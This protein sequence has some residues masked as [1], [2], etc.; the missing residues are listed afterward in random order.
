MKKEYEEDLLRQIRALE[1]ERDKYKYDHLTNLMGRIDFEEQFKKFHKDFLESK[2]DFTFGILDINDLHTLNRLEGYDIGDEL[3][4]DISKE[5]RLLFPDSYI[6]RIGGD[7]FALLCRHL[8]CPIFYQ[9][10]SP[11]LKKHVT[12]GIVSMGEIVDN[13]LIMDQKKLFKFVDKLVITKKKDGN[14]GR[15]SS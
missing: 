14:L 11:L 12:Y 15:N 9:R 8:S 6:Y 4:Q 7:E 2:I 5:L 3:I 1:K 10:V 13:T